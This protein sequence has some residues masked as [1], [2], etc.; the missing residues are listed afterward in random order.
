MITTRRPDD[1]G[2]CHLYNPKLAIT[3]TLHHLENG[4]ASDPYL[5]GCCEN[6]LI[7][8]CESIF[9]AAIPAHA[10][11][12]SL[13]IVSTLTKPKRTQFCAHY[14]TVTSMHICL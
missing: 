11:L 4:L 14:H 8:F 7:Y 10:L 12:F 9:L 3:H 13:V 1:S 2:S 5:D 6:A